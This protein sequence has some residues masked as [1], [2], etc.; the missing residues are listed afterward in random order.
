MKL[1]F[2]PKQNPHPTHSKGSR[3]ECTLIRIRRKRARKRT[4]VVVTLMIWTSARQLRLVLSAW[5]RR[6]SSSADL[7]KPKA[8]G[9]GRDSLGRRLLSLIYP[10]RSALVVLR[11]WAEEGKTIQKYQLNRVV[12]ELRKYKRF[13]HALE[14][15]SLLLCSPYLIRL[16]CNAWTWTS[17][18]AFSLVYPRGGTGS[19]KRCLKMP[20]M[21]YTAS[22]LFF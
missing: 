13:K 2:E 7:A 4:S 22:K 21:C 11:K 3:R 15:S 9:S 20:C 8:D 19:A 18:S 5:A 16:V 12:R 1:R 10:K 6:A 14:V 17:C